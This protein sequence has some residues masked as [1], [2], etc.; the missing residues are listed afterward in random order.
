MIPTRSVSSSADRPGAAALAAAAGAAAAGVAVVG[1]G[2]PSRAGNLF[3]RCPFHAVTGLWCPGCGTLRAV[4]D[5]VHG[6]V[7]AGAGR[8]PLLVVLAP[9]LVWSVLGWLGV[10]RRPDPPAWALVALGVVVV[11]FTVLRNVPVS[12]FAALAP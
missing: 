12:P 10:V 7:L 1:L 6:H 11:A 2:D 5:V 9:L 4:H 8:N 3:P